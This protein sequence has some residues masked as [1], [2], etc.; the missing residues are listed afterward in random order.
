MEPSALAPADVDI[1]ITIWI[2]SQKIMKIG[3]LH[4]KYSMDFDEI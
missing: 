1:L 2:L 4:K 3:R